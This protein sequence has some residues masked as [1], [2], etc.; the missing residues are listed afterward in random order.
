MPT[1]HNHNQLSHNTVAAA[2]KCNISII[3]R[4]LN[5]ISVKIQGFDDIK[6]DW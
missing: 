6:A 4:R 5:L 1:R 3:F 2:V